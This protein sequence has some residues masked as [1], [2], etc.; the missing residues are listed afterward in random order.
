MFNVI[1]VL[2]C[3]LTPYACYFAVLHEIN[4]FAQYVVVKEVRLINEVLSVL[5]MHLYVFLKSSRLCFFF[6]PD[7]RDKQSSTAG[8]D[9]V[10]DKGETE[11]S[12]FWQN[13]CWAIEMIV[14]RGVWVNYFSEVS[15]R[16]W[17]NMIE[18]IDSCR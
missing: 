8:N 6:Q 16:E 14:V 12:F 11:F 1:K 9:S 15:P 17:P 4:I 18:K 10:D 2:P 3:F 13:E 5:R 7:E